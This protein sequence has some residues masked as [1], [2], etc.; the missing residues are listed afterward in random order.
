MSDRG[1]YM[2]TEADVELKRAPGF[3]GAVRYLW[4]VMAT[5]PS[6]KGYDV[7]QL[8]NPGFLSLRCGRLRMVF[9]ILKKNNRS[10]FLTLC[11]NDYFFVKDCAEGE[12]FRFSEFRVGKE[13]T[14]MVEADPWKESGWLLDEHKRYTRHLYGAID[15]AMSVLPEYDMS[16]KAHMDPAKVHFTNIPVELDSLPYAP[17]ELEGP[18]KVLVGMKAEMAVQK[19][20][21][22]LL[23]ICREIES[24]HP[25]KVL[26]DVASG[27]SLEEYLKKLSGSHVV[28]DQLYSY[29]PATNALQ[30]MALGRVSA[31]GWQPECAAMLGCTDAPVIPLQPG[32]DVKRVLE[33]ALLDVGGLRRMSKAGRELVERE[34]D[35]RTVADKF[36]KHWSDVVS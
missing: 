17:L 12:M 14:E 3:L 2:H 33:N 11:G 8:I 10:V 23:E 35:V 16:A 20:T 4:K 21:S 34:N 31:T 15:G 28:V 30:T 18:V 1:G 29:S 7:V 25:G 27:L 26:V 13:N 5:L 36:L 9:D 32:D 24:E 22:K 6:W 19:G